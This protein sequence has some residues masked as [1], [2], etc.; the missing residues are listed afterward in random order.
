MYLGKTIGSPAF[1]DDDECTVALLATH[2]AIAIESARQ[3]AALREGDEQLRRTLTMAPVRLFSQD[4]QLRYTML[5]GR[6]GVDAA[7]AL[8]STDLDLLSP[9]DAAEIVAA[10]RRVL[11][12]GVATRVVV[13]VTAPDGPRYYDQLIEPSFDAGGR[14]V[15]VTGASWDVTEQ[16][17]L[18]ARLEAAEARTRRLIEDAPEP[19]ILSEP[20]GRC[21]DV[22]VAFCEL[23]GYARDEV[24]GRAT[25]ELIIHADTSPRLDPAVPPDR[26]G[27][28]P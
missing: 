20:D 10:K 23:L 4:A 7:R 28:T 17:R 18:I 8:G 26:L 14:C 21:V 2:A 1:S 13:Q 27:V 11:G 24:V 15:G 9:T 19:Y 25:A 3:Y 6:G 22:N 16:R 5:L 12:T